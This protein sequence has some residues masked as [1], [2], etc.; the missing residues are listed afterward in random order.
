VRFW[1]QRYHLD[2]LR[3]DAVAYSNG[4]GEIAVAILRLEPPAMEFSLATSVQELPRPAGHA[5]LTE[6]PQACRGSKID[7]TSAAKDAL[8]WVPAGGY[9]HPV[10]HSGL[11]SRCAGLWVV[12]AS[13]PAPQTN[14][15][16]TMSPLSIKSRN[17]KSAA[18]KKG[19]A[20][21]KTAFRREV[22]SPAANAKKPARTCLA[23]IHPFQIFRS[24]R[25]E[26]FMA[27]RTKVRAK[28]VI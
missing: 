10:K 24:R 21:S 14:G 9:G 16:Q 12:R 20:Q 17:T 8:L 3:V 19:S 7:W 18:P 23:L 13:I 5:F 28:A 25:E 4:E 1:V 6:T 15:A 27:V 22:T 26:N 11:A 2:G